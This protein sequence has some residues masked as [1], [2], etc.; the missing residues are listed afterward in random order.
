MC[1][2]LTPKL[3]KTPPPGG[4]QKGPAYPSATPPRRSPFRWGLLVIVALAFAIRVV[5]A[6]QIGA[7]PLSRTPQY[8]SLEY[9]GWAKHLV[10]QDL[11]WP[12]MPPHGPGYPFFLAGLLVLTGSSLTAVRIIQALAGAL[13]CLF[14]ARAATRWFG[15]RAGL[16][17]GALL[18]VYAPLIWIDVSIFCEGLLLTLLAA[19]LCGF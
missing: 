8:D 18:A 12:A 19:A 14:P 13:A 17:T 11:T 2:H 4:R 15:K 3:G 16:A 10:T 6:L 7:M 1:P 5:V 9:L